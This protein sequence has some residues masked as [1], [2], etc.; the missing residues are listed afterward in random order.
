M[1]RSGTV[2][3]THPKWCV[4]TGEVYDKQLRNFWKYLKINEVW[5]RLWWKRSD[6]NLQNTWLTTV[7]KPLCSLTMPKKQLHQNLQEQQNWLVFER[8]KGLEMDVL[9]GSTH[10][11]RSGA[12]PSF[13]YSPGC[14]PHGPLVLLS[15]PFTTRTREVLKPYISPFFDPW[16]SRKSKDQTKKHQTCPS[17]VRCSCRSFFG[18]TRRWPE[19]H[20]CEE[21]FH[22]LS[23]DPSLEIF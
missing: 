8:K 7:A 12:R 15:L 2:T 20:P 3:F 14:I 6:S 23:F 10:L 22:R 11:L 4:L 9:Q 18:R 17:F 16:W 1:H 19:Y 21:Q 5:S 13:R